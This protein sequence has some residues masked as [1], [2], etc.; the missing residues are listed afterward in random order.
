MRN[1][2]DTNKPAAPLPPNA[3]AWGPPTKGVPLP[4]DAI[5]QPDGGFWVFAYGSLIWNPE[6][7]VAERRP[8]ALPGYRRSFCL[9]SVHY[10]G[11]RERPGLILGLEEAEGAVTKGQALRVAPE[12]AKAA[13]EALIE[14]E[15]FLATYKET[16]LPAQILCETTGGPTGRQTVLAYVVDKSHEQYAGTLSPEEKCAVIACAHGSR[17]PNAEYLFNL[18]EM[19]RAQGLSAEELSNL[20]RLDAGVRAL[21]GNGAA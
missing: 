14:R 1:A 15:L 18:V 17:G 21:L 8:A 2:D 7:E 6:I 10:R 5:L 13:H 16:L 4:H 20:E 3:G 11:T 9:W 19:L 12:H